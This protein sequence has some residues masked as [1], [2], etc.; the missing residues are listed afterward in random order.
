MTHTTYAKNRVPKCDG[1]TRTQ[2]RL[3][4]AIRLAKKELSGM[5]KAPDIIP[6]RTSIRDFRGEFHYSRLF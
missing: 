1:N 5:D 3:N 6:M 2:N 4:L